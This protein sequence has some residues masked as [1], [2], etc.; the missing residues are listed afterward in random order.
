VCSYFLVNYSKKFFVLLHQPTFT[1][2]YRDIAGH[3][4]RGCQPTG[5][6]MAMVALW[7]T[8]C[9]VLRDGLLLRLLVT[10]SMGKAVRS[11][12][13]F[14]VSTDQH[15][16][17]IDVLS[18]LSEIERYNN[19]KGIPQEK[20]DNQLDPYSLFVSQERT[21]TETFRMGRRRAWMFREEGQTGVDFIKSTMNW[22][23]SVD[24][25]EFRLRV[26]K[27]QVEYYKLLNR[28]ELPR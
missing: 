21:V 6:F 27:Y 2:Q 7:R 23:T 13:C 11:T 3:H 15:H 18:P 24:S 17:W 9:Q 10:A 5:V 26:N 1:R 19:N 22:S 14:V 25:W 16:G 20:E 12:V 28:D 8:D 4:G